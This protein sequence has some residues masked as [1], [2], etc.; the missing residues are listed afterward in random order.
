MLLAP[1]G[2]PPGIYVPT[3]CFFKPGEKQ[4]VDYETIGKH[5][6]RLIKAGITGL[7]VHGTTGEPPHLSRAERAEVIKTTRSA[8]DAA[9]LQN[10]PLI[11]GCGV[12]STWETIDLCKEAKELGGNFVIVIA[13]AYFKAAMSDEALE[14]HYTA[15]ADASPLPMLLYNF[16]GVANGIDLDFPIISKLAKHT[17]IVGIKLSCGN[18]AKGARLAATYK[19]SEFEVFGGLADGLLAGLINGSQGVIVGLANIAPKAVIR[20]FDA[21]QKQDL[22]AAK[23]HMQVLAL[24]GEIELKGGI[25]GMRAA[26]QHFF[27]YGGSS[28]LPMLDA[29]EEQKSASIKWCEPLIAGEK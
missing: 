17:N 7:V 26:L 18:I 24:A 1:A 2:P 9:G 5:A 4:E 15:V 25:P 27:G 19:P 23:Q 10:T 22:A 8:L 14:K 13:P 3:L 16:P 6:V 28:R 20:V 11:I 29:T 12:S 21:F